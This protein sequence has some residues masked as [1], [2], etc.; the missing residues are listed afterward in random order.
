MALSSERRFEEAIALCFQTIP[1]SESSFLASLFLGYAF[2]QLGRLPE[3][4]NHLRCALALGPSDYYA[5]LFF[6]R[7]LQQRGRLREALGHYTTCCRADAPDV[8]EPF[9]AGMN[10]GSGLRETDEGV[11]FALRYEQLRREGHIPDPLAAR[12]LFLWHRDAD[13]TAL[14]SH[15]DGPE[16]QRASIRYIHSVE[17]WASRTISGTRRSPR[18][19]QRG[20]MWRWLKMPRSSAIPA[21]F[22]SAIREYFPTCWPSPHTAHK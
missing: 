17:D 5:N 18:S 2:F 19:L 11:A 21:S 7:T 3:A 4:E 20:L 13:L 1:R 15:A 12:F 8:A 22:M 9:E 10:V 6:A 14:L 16:E